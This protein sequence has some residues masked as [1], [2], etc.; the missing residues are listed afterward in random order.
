[1]RRRWRV[2]KRRI[3]FL[4]NITICWK[5]II[6]TQSFSSSERLRDENTQKTV[7][8]HRVLQLYIIKSGA[9][10][11]STLNT[12]SLSA[13]VRCSKNNFM[14]ISW[15]RSNTHSLEHNNNNF[16]GCCNFV[17]I[18]ILCGG[19]ER[20][21]NENELCNRRRAR[22]IEWNFFW[23]EKEE[24]EEINEVEKYSRKVKIC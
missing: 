13:Y 1:M 2:C 15:Q 7:F 3:S 5:K 16:L 6:K 17:A 24:A 10:W 8:L 21:E 23:G 14:P 9:Y 22:K 11:F 19:W 18:Y 12:R 20:H 4:Y